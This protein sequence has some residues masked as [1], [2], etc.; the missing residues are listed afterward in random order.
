MAHYSYTVKFIPL[1]LK[2]LNLMNK[3]PCL[4]LILNT[5][6]QTS[7]RTMVYHA[8]TAS[9]NCGHL[10]PRLRFL[11]P[12]S[13]R[14]RRKTSLLMSILFIW[15][16]LGVVPNCLVA[17]SI[18]FDCVSLGFCSFS[19]QRCFFWMADNTLWF[20]LGFEGLLVSSIAIQDSLYHA[21]W[22]QYLFRDAP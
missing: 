15:L 14:I 22:H 18:S 2:Y 6:L 17:Y 12:S 7:V 4:M 13:S 16:M 8:S 3:F 19:R 11:S 21:D 9:S 5:L 1:Q 10:A 20:F